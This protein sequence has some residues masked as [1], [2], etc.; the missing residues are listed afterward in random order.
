MPN[1]RYYCMDDAGAIFFGD[2]LDT[3]DLLGAIAECRYIA[4]QKYWDR[5]RRIEIWDNQKLLYQA[6]DL[7]ATG[8]IV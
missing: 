1:F 5:V 3:P 4:R 2:Y 8:T 6:S 7:G